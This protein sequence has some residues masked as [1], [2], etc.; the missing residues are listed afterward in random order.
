MSSSTRLY[1]R[2]AR[3]SA[4]FQWMRFRNCCCRN[5]L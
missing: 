2:L 4:L 3:T 5:C 1:L